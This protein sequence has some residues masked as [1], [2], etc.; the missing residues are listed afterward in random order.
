[1]K[2]FT[3]KDRSEVELR[4]SQEIKN[5]KDWMYGIGQQIQTLSENMISLSLNHEKVLSKSESDK[6][7]ILI[8]FENLHENVRNT[9]DEF[10]QRIGDLESRC[11]HLQ[12]LLGDK[13][14]D[15]SNKYLTKED[16]SEEAL[17][18]IEKL[19]IILKVVQE[20][21]DFNKTEF[22][23]IRSQIS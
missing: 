8:A 16:H 5:H 13:F 21:H 22:V 17:K 3:L 9:L 19:D 20:N 15:F 1:M 7:E 6:K 14:S 12:L 2:T 11:I 10:C 4:V 18:R 23:S